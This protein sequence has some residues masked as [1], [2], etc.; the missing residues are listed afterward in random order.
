MKRQQVLAP[1]GFANH[2]HFRV[3]RPRLVYFLC[4]H[5][6]AGALVAVLEHVADQRAAATA[7]PESAESEG[8]FGGAKW[9]SAMLIGACLRLRAPAYFLVSGYIRAMRPLGG[10]W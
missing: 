3:L 8:H 2:I 1:R 4:S 5:L 6:P 10:P 9:R 7:G